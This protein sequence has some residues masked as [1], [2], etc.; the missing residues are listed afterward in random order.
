MHCKFKF[1]PS[2]TSPKLTALQNDKSKISYLITWFSVETL[3][4]KGHWTGITNSF[5][6]QELGSTMHTCLATLS[7]SGLSQFLSTCLPSNLF[8]F[9]TS[10]IFSPLPIPVFIFH[11]VPGYLPL[12]WQ[13]CSQL[14]NLGCFFF[15]NFLN[16]FLHL[17][18]QYPIPFYH[19][20][21]DE[22]TKH[23]LLF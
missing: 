20:F 22:V 1:Q 11:C 4:H 10:L 12:H 17:P 5:S 18:Q 9:N 23:C 21:L 7:W 19:N 16:L 15:L 6:Y 2:P 8:F 14:E 13:P 3:S